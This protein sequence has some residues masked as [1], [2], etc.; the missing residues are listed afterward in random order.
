MS[1]FNV[2]FVFIE[3]LNKSENPPVIIILKDF[4]VSFLIKL[5]ILSIKP[6]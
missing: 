1:L 3:F 5:I 4:L 2:T 6:A